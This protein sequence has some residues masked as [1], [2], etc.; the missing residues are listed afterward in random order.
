MVT[1]TPYDVGMGASD[2]DNGMPQITGTSGP[3]VDDSTGMSKTQRLTSSFP[4]LVLKDFFVDAQ[5]TA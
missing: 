2:L 3:F 5:G 1:V 4:A